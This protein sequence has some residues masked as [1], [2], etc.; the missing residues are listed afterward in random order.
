M[1][2]GAAA[3]IAV[4]AAMSLISAPRKHAE[5][6]SI[7]GMIVFLDPGHNGANDASISRQVTNGRGGT[8]ECQTS[9]T[10]A[11]DGYPE[12]PKVVGLSDAAL[13]MDV[14]GLCYTSRR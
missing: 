11:D 14:R 13:A 2:V 8:K 5:P 4:I 1:R 12:H 6:T 10:T 3:A 9:G 7:A